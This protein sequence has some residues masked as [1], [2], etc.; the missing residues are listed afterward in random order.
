MIFVCIFEIIFLNLSWLF[1]DHAIG[2]I[3]HDSA[4]FDSFL[5]CIFF[6]TFSIQRTRLTNVIRMLNVC[7]PPMSYLPRGKTEIK[8]RSNFHRNRIDRVCTEY[9][10]LKQFFVFFSRTIHLCF[11]FEHRI[12]VLRTTFI[13]KV[14]HRIC[15]LLLIVRLS[16]SLPGRCVP[17]EVHVLL[18]RPHRRI[19]FLGTFQHGVVLSDRYDIIRT[20]ICTIFIWRHDVSNKAFVPHRTFAGGRVAEKGESKGAFNPG[21]HSQGAPNHKKNILHAYYYISQFIN[22]I[23]IIIIFHVSMFYFL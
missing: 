19:K 7:A 4:Q 9:Y 16:S 11:P 5:F 20:H 13:R 2:V 22:Y 21:P 8:H 6:N 12:H 3:A 15:F 14:R 10:Q 17:A 18:L 1:S 23:N